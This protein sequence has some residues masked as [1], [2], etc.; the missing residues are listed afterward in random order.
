MGKE[1]EKYKVNRGTQEGNVS[2]NIHKYMNRKRNTTF[3]IEEN[4]VRGRKYII[5]GPYI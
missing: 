5:W 4:S 3:V 1:I 2:K